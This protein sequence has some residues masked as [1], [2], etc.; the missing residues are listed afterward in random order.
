MQ[1]GADV[2]LFARNPVGAQ[3]LAT[4]FGVETR[5]FAT[6]IGQPTNGFRDFDI[7]VNT[8]PL[9]TRG[10]N[11]N[12]TIAIAEQIR[13]AKLVYDLVYN[14]SETRLL[15]EAK[16]AGI[17]TIGGMEMLITQA[18]KQFEIWTGRAAPI[19]EMRAAVLARI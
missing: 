14:P 8:T 3:V 5:R 1:E 9:G 6:S 16:K 4:S 7:I 10:E 13:D 15:T 12:S 11:E 19:D 18:A 17:A 2:T